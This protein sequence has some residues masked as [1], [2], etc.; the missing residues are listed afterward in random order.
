MNLKTPILA[1]WPNLGE[2]GESQPEAWSEKVASPDVI[3]VLEKDQERTKKLTEPNQA[4]T[5]HIVK[6][7]GGEKC[8]IAFDFFPAFSKLVEVK[9]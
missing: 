5:L 9:S 2:I 4:L 8:K 3:L 6:N 1:I 7:R